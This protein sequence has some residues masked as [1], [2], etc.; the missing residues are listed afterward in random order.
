MQQLLRP[1]CLA[2]A[3]VAISA[4]AHAGL[5]ANL[6]LAESLALPGGHTG[7]YVFGGL[8]ADFAAGP[9]FLTPWLGAEVSPDAERWGFVFS[10]NLDLPISETVGIDLLLSTVH[11]QAGARWAEASFYQGFGLGV[12]IAADPFVVSPALLWFVGLDAPSHGLSPAVNVA[13]AL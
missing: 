10:L 9:L 13:L 12:S 11:D 8:S 2:L 6:G 1:R 3:T 4:P 5:N 7:L